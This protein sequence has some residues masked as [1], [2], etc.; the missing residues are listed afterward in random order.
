MTDV[1]D[2]GDAAV[3]AFAAL[4]VEVALLRRAVEGLAAERAEEAAPDYSVTLGEI[5]RQVE[6]QARAIQ[7]LAERPALGLTPETITRQ[8]TAA[9]AEARRE[10]VAAL[11]EAQMAM[12]RTA[13]ALSRAMKSGRTANE[14]RRWVIRSAVG[15][16]VAGALLWAFVPGMILRALPESWTAMLSG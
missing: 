16:M 5:V 14:Q 2:S 7:A 1:E 6:R 4:R 11:R 3:E 13:A 12:E 8:I 9:G 15:G 10:D